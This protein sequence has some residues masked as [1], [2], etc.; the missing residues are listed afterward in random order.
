MMVRLA[1][2]GCCPNGTND[3]PASP[4]MMQPPAAA[5]A[6]L[7]RQLLPCGQ[8][9]SGIVSVRTHIIFAAKQQSIICPQDNIIFAQQ[10]HH[11]N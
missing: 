1:A 3:V 10:I 7:R 4:E 5:I 9:R 8:H 6:A 2:I 11:F